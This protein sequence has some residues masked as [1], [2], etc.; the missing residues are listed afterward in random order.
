MKRTMGI[1]DFIIFLL[2]IT[3]LLTAFFMNRD[4]F[5]LLIGVGLMILL[6]IAHIRLEKITGLSRENPKLKTMRRMNRF[7][8]VFVAIV[9][10]I[11]LANNDWMDNVPY[12]FFLLITIMIFSGNIAP[13]LP[14]NKYMGLRL[15]WTTRDEHTWKIANRLLGYLTF[16]LVLLMAI[17]F[18]CFDQS[19]LI[20][21]LG[22]I[23][24]IGV[25]AVYSLI[26]CSEIKKARNET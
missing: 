25:P 23:V 11:P 13:K 6:G 21:L 10:L 26:K 14:F 5:S 1:L 2:S 3:V 22:I 4:Q 8:V 16:P 18:F 15:P 12:Q 24:W 9:Y 7:S 20:L 17:L 19:E